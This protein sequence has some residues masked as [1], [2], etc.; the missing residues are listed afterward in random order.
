MSVQQRTTRYMCRIFFFLFFFS[1]SYKTLLNI[2]LYNEIFLTNGQCVNIYS[3]CLGELLKDPEERDEPILKV[4]EN[5]NIESKQNLYDEYYYKKKILIDNICKEYYKLMIKAKE[6]ESNKNKNFNDIK[7]FPKSD[8]QKDNLS[9]NESLEVQGENCNTITKSPLEIEKNKSVVEL[10]YDDRNPEINF[11]TNKDNLKIARY[12][13]KIENPK[14]YIFALHGLT[15]HLR[16]EYLICSG[17]PEWVE[18]NRKEGE[19]VNETDYSIGKIL[20]YFKEYSNDN[21]MFKILYDKIEFMI[22]EKLLSTD[23]NELTNI[24]KGNDVSSIYNNVFKNLYD[25]FEVI[26]KENLLTKDENEIT[27]INKGKDISDIYNNMFKSLYDKVEVIFKENLLTKDENEITNIKKE[28]DISDIYNNIFKTVYDKM[29]CI[30]KEKIWNKDGKETLNEKNVVDPNIIHNNNEEE[31]AHNVNANGETSEGLSNNNVEN[32]DYKRS[33]DNDVTSN[34]D[35]NKNIVQKENNVS[36]LYDLYDVLKDNFDIDIESYALY[37][38]SNI[39]ENSELF[40]SLSLYL[41]SLEGIY[42][43]RNIRSLL[44][45]QLFDDIGQ[46]A[47]NLKMFV[48]DDNVLLMDET[49]VNDYVDNKYYFCSTCGI[50]DSCNC[51]KRVLSYKNSWIEKFNN[52]GFTFIGIDNQ[53]HGLS[54]GARN[55]RCFVE[56][57]ENF[58]LDT[59]QALEIFINEYKEKNELKPIIIL[60]TSM[61][62]CIALRTIEAIYKGNKEWKDN[63]KGLVLISPMISIENHKRKLINRILYRLCRYVKKYIPLYEMDLLYEKHKYPWIKGDTDIDPNHYSDGVKLGAATECVLA[64]DKCLIPEILKYIEE[65]DMDIFVL[66]SKY[67]N[68][69]D[70]TGPVDFVKKMVELYN[71]NDDENSNAKG[72]D[73]ENETEGLNTPTASDE[74]NNDK[75]KRDISLR[76]EN[77]SKADDIQNDITGACQNIENYVLLSGN[78]LTEQQKLW[79]SCD[80]GYYKNFLTKRLGKTNDLNTKN[81]EDSFKRLSAH[82]LNY[83]SHRLACEPDTERTVKIL[84]DWL[85]NIFV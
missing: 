58:V 20:D 44:I 60:G 30:I 3:R 1:V 41:S 14:A 78:D 72:D 28:K 18:R 16:N 45:K 83:G 66:Q 8:E 50:C 11:F 49:D 52:N 62:G 56:N 4:S 12:T 21:N 71:K 19:S 59:V 31:N 75:E 73:N 81:G 82:I 23:E 85:N 48:N 34:S 17:M 80:H 67:D 5:D 27:N 39:N 46:Y 79:Y 53:S 54:D 37:N 57:F 77:I 70:P 64:A 13:W 43:Y 25:K 32:K 47:N 22:K 61:G 51:G 7:E 29:E 65:S 10:L 74:T 35:I 84:I 40:E 15:T 6:N 36:M 2:Y 42:Y 26:I 68:T 38:R 63:I 69:V 33:N 9:S 76:D 24:N 55:Q